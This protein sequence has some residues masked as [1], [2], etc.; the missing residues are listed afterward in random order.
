MEIYEVR[1]PNELV[2]AGEGVE[3]EAVDAGGEEG[4]V[5]IRPARCREVREDPVLTE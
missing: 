2:V 1:D 3:A 4:G 5:G